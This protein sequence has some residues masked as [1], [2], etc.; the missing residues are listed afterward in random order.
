MKVVQG[1]VARLPFDATRAVIRYHRQI[2][3]VIGG[4]F[5]V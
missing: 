1:P 2:V 3:F 4:G 5:C